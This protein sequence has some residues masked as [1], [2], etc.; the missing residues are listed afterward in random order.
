[1][2]PDPTDPLDRR[3]RIILYAAFAVWAA[4]ALLGEARFVLIL[5]RSPGSENVVL[6]RAS[7]TALWAFLAA[8]AALA[9]RRALLTRFP[10][11]EDEDA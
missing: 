6:F 2:F 9:C 5:L 4:V 8:T 10:D 11:P 3:L 7:V 1:M